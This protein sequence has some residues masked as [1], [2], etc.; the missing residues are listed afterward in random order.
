M[1]TKTPPQSKVIYKYVK[2]RRGV[3]VGC[4]LARRRVDGTVGIGFSLCTPG[5]LD[6]FDRK[7]AYDIAN[8]RALNGSSDNSPQSL[9]S[10]MFEMKD[11]A[12]RYF[13]PTTPI[14]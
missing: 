6:T 9:D 4:V 8:G 3:P 7:I 12:N 11:R 14:S 10:E 5:R 2:N 1:T 13:K